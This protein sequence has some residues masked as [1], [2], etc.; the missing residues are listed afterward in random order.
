MET[1]R[2]RVAYIVAAQFQIKIGEIREDSSF[3]D[4]LG[5]D[6]LDLVELAVEL[7]EEFDCE[8]TNEDMGKMTTVQKAVAHIETLINEVTLTNNDAN[9]R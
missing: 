6:S 3:T 5:A 2:E 9:T 4:E 7:E 1:V 8:I